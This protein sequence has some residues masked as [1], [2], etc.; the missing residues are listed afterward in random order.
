MRRPT[1]CYPNCRGAVDP[2]L[3]PP[4]PCPHRCRARGRGHR[5]RRRVDDRAEPRLGA[6]RHARGLRPLAVG[7]EG[8]R[9]L[10][11]AM[12]VR[13]GE[14]AGASRAERDAAYADAMRTV[15]RAISGRRGRA[16]AVRRRD[17]EP[18][19]LE[20]LDQGRPSAAGHDRARRRP[21]EGDRPPAEPR[22]R[23]P[24]LHP[25]GRSL[26]DA[27]ARAA[28]RRA[29]A[30]VDARRG[31]RRPHARARLPARR[32]LRGRGA[33]EHRRRRGRQPLLRLAD[34]AGDLSDVLR[35]AQPALPVGDLPAV[36][37]SARRR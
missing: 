24:L 13:Y 26:A 16:G 29:P 37:A 20:S 14:P 27:G 6:G 7:P 33:R 11:E 36:R 9:A 25:R 32:P 21:V 18:P 1:L 2:D 8:E 22:R 23:V 3:R 19:A 28:V 5:A 17:D 31:P 15:A 34:G 10:I 30:A 4:P 12:A 35:T